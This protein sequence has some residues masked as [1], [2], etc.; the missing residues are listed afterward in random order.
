MENA[1]DKPKKMVACKRCGE[2]GLHWEQD[3][4]GWRL[5]SPEGVVHSCKKPD[6]SQPK[7]PNS[8]FKN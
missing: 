6:A 5:F 3:V 7:D 4:K 8:S 2:A 1:N